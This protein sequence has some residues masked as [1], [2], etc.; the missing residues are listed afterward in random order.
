MI[1]VIKCTSKPCINGYPASKLECPTCHK[2]A[3]FAA[4]D[5]FFLTFRSGWGFLDPSSVARSASKRTVSTVLR[6]PPPEHPLNNHLNR[7]GEHTSHC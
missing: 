3:L 7:R 4:E 6:A 2:L 1:Q 5:T